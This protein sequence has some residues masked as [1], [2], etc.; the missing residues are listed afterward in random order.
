MKQQILAES[1]TNFEVELDKLLCKF[2]ES[3][4]G[5]RTPNHETLRNILE[6]RCMWKLWTSKQLFYR[7]ELMALMAP[8]DD[9][10][11]SIQDS[12]RLQASQAIS[13]RERKVTS[14]I[15]KYMVNM[16][17]PPPH[18]RCA[19]NVTRWL[20]LWQ[21]MLIYRQSLGLVMEQHQQTNATP[22]SKAG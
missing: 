4:S 14:G 9:R 18:L 7:D 15:D 19:S 8:C 2:V 3:P 6:M 16:D 11:S 22:R 21:M 13:E 12:L 10:V 5:P 20:L 1:E 17:A